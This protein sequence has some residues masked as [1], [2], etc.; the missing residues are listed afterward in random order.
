MMSVSPILPDLALA[1]HLLDCLAARDR[2]ALGYWWEGQWYE[3][4]AYNDNA[5]RPQAEAVA[6]TDDPAAW[7]ADDGTAT[8]PKASNSPDRA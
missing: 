3:C 1:Q 8:G 5:L 2:A 6:C 7:A 4:V